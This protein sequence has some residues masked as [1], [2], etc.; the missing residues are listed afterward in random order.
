MTRTATAD[1]RT[2]V[3]TV[4]LSDD[5]RHRVREAC[6]QE[7]GLRLLEADT[8]SEAVSILH[9]LRPGV[10]IVNLAMTGG[11]P[12]AVTDYA[13]F[14]FPDIRILYAMG[15]GRTGFEDGSVFAHCANAHGCVTPSMGPGDM[16]AF[17]AHHAMPAAA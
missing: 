15:E 3:L 7:E 5:L 14:L 16:A 12:M 10:M 13:A 1:A 11:S 17:V 6:G 4:G 9:D 2:L 8:Q